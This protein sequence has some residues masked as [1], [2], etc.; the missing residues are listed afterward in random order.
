MA[1]ALN[2]G[3]QLLDIPQ[4]SILQMSENQMEGQKRAKAVCYAQTC[5]P[6]HDQPHWQW[7]TV[8]A[9]LNW[10]FST[11][12]KL[13]ALHRKVAAAGLAHISTYLGEITIQLRQDMAPHVVEFVQQIA[14]RKL[15]TGCNFYR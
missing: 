1:A 10:S 5:M 3:S 8:A 2:N 11:R 6:L 15:C 4:S 13:D 12:N 14:Q 7:C 9:L